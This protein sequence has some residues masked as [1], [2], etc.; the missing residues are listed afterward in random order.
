ML[1]NPEKRSTTSCVGSPARTECSTSIC[2]TSSDRDDFIE[3]WPD[4]GDIDHAR[5]INILADEGYSDV[6]DPDHVPDHVDDPSGKQAYAHGYG[7]ILG[8]INGAAHRARGR[9]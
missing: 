3:A 1:W 2:A 9:S 6:V 5:I 4:E 8:A 7:F